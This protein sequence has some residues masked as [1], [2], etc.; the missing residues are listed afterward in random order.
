MMSLG[1]SA[2]GSTR[3]SLSR[4]RLVYR[5]IGISV[6]LG[7]I[8]G[9][10]VG[11]VAL[12]S[13]FLFDVQGLILVWGVLG[14]AVLTSIVSFLFMTFTRQGWLFAARNRELADHGAE[15]ALRTGVEIGVRTIDGAGKVAC[16]VGDA[17]GDVDVSL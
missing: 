6:F 7:G 14:A 17:A 11:C 16:A 1:T 12:V 5:A 8:C 9:F 10:V 3:K 13:H 2:G 15:M 4:I